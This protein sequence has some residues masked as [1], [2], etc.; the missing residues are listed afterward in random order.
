MWVM[1][2]LKTAMKVFVKANDI[3]SPQMDK[4]YLLDTMI[5]NHYLGAIVH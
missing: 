2:V 5:I 1:K 4:N 3:H